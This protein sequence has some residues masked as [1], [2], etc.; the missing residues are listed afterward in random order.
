MDFLKQ[1]LNTKR[2]FYIVSFVLL[3]A[4]Y[5]RTLSYEYV[6]DDAYLLINNPAIVSRELRIDLLSRPLFENVGYFR[7][8]VFFSWWLETRLW[9]DLNPYLSHAV[10]L[11][12][13]YGLIIIVFNLINLLLIKNNV[14]KNTIAISAICLFIYI[15]HPAN[16]ETVVWIAGRF[17][18][19]ATFFIFLTIYIFVRMERSYLRDL[20]IVLTTSCALLSKETGILLLV[21]L[22]MM[23]LY[24]R[25][26]GEYAWSKL[27]GDFYGDNRRLILAM[28]LVYGIYLI[29]RSMATGHSANHLP[30]DMVF[31]KKYYIDYQAPIISIQEYITRTIFPFF[32]NGYFNQFT[33]QS[34][35]KYVYSWLVVV[36]YFIVL[37][38]LLKA[39]NSKAML[40]LAYLAGI[41]LVINLIP[42]NRM[43]NIRQDRFLFLSN[44]FFFILLSQLITKL[45][46]STKTMQNWKPLVIFSYATAMAVATSV[47]MGVWR[48]EE[49]FWERNNNI[50]QSEYADGQRILNPYFYRLVAKP[51]TDLNYIRGILAKEKKYSFRTG[52]EL[53]LALFTNYA[54]ASIRNRSQEEGLIILEELMPA[55]EMRQDDLGKERERI[56]NIVGIYNIYVEGLIYVRHDFNRAKEYINKIKNIDLKEF[57]KNI[58]LISL[59]MVVSL[60]LN[61]P[62]ELKEDLLLLKQAKQSLVSDK[63][64]L[65]E[66]DEL[67]DFLVG[68]LCP[69]VKA[70]VPACQPNFSMRAYREKLAN[71]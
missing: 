41:A 34:G 56:Q 54:R 43:E 36:I 5:G 59:D 45:F 15:A 23:Y 52:K 32:N 62:Q 68:E 8:L 22:P 58:S 31:I 57:N 11:L 44:I 60:L 66:A 30:F 21:L 29:I 55:Y 10:N 14:I 2:F 67:V 50:F 12:F 37:I 39:K 63:T 51:E 46:N 19:F 71:E 65:E 3:L 38:Y 28:L 49:V 70:D 53:E 4:L 20:L 48:D 40:L 61:K 27:L 69:V 1:H 16:V 6:W 64:P 13:F 24:V 42:L 7:P 17:D 18:L 25:Q 35:E 9:G 26:N 33:Y 47:L